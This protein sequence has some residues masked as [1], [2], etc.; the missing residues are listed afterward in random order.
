MFFISL[1]PE[2]LIDHFSL[3]IFPNKMV[4]NPDKMSL[5]N[6]APR[7]S[8]GARFCYLIVSFI[9]ALATESN[10]LEYKDRLELI[11]IQISLIKI[12]LIH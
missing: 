4:D 11:G 7:L 2:G 8:Q 10:M 12:S 1:V 5:I 6:A 9:A 3:G